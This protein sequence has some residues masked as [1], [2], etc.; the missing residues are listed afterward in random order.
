MAVPSTTL[1]GNPTRLAAAAA[2][3]ASSGRLWAVLLEG[4]TAAS[5]I[6]FHNHATEASG[7]ALMG[8][9]APFTDADASAASTVFVSFVELGGI[10]FSTGIYGNL[11]GTGAVAYV[12]Y[13]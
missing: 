5:S 6:D 2:V 7:T 4:G 3:K 12:W 8:I 13:S 9:T 11:A 1:F 10:E